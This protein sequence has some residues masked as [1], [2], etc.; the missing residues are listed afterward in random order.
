M[1]HILDF[2]ELNREFLPIVGGKNANL[3]EMIRSG[4]LVPPGFAITTD[5]YAQ[6][7]EQ[8]GIRNRIFEILFHIDLS[9]QKSLYGASSEIQ[10]LIENSPI[11]DDIQNAIR[12][13][14]SS[15]CARCARESLSVAIR[16]S[17]TAE[18]TPTASFAGQQDTYLCVEGI[19][20]V[21]SRVRRCWASLFTPRAISYREKNAFP[22]EKVRMSVGVQKMI[23]PVAAGVMFTL[24]PV[25]GD[26]SKIVIEASWGL[27]EAVVSGTVTPDRFVVD[28]VLYNILERFI[29]TK[30]TLYA[31]DSATKEVAKYEVEQ[32]RQNCACLSDQD[33]IRIAQT[34]KSIEKHFGSPQDIEWALDKDLNPPGN[35]FLLQSRPETVWSKKTVGAITKKDQSY[36]DYMADRFIE[37]W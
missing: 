22:H 29:G 27:G 2:D 31:L 5:C 32:S 9:D 14:Y 30:Q 26:L 10:S 20:Q 36:M 6:F 11:P 15:L 33:L 7:M 1:K 24:N 12:V 23:N 16:S 19:D 18:D 34:G 8:A 4:T 21:L 13:G 28:K 35:L 17:A 3:G 37:G 25:N